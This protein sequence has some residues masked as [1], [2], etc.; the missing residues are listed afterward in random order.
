M[1]FERR[2]EEDV[3]R[4]FTTWPRPVNLALGAALVLVGGFVHIHFAPLGYLAVREA[5]KEAGGMQI[6]E[7]IETEGYWHG[8]TDWAE[9]LKMKECLGCAD[10]I[11]RQDFR[12][13]DFEAGEGAPGIPAGFVR[14][15]LE[16]AGDPNCVAGVSR[17]KPPMGMCVAALRLSHAPLTGYRYT[18]SIRTNREW[19]GV[20][21]RE[22]TRLIVTVESNR[23]VARERYFDYATPWEAYGKLARRYHCERAASIPLTATGFLKLTI[24]EE[25]R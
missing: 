6:F 18:D 22:M 10:A 13:I 19:F 11:A 16:P 20:P 14:Y 2:L 24:R 21:L 9:G 3:K 15:Q 17:S 8:G 1:D 4:F 12:Y 23:V 7:H 5:C 25:A